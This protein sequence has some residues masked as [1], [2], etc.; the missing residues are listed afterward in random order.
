MSVPSKLVF[1]AKNSRCAYQYSYRAHTILTIHHFDWIFYSSP[2]MT[3]TYMSR[4][5]FSNVAKFWFTPNVLSFL[6]SNDLGLGELL[7]CCEASEGICPLKITNTLVEYLC[8]FRG[9]NRYQ[10]LKTPAQNKENQLHW[11]KKKVLRIEPISAR[12][13]ILISLNAFVLWTE[14]C[15][16]QLSVRNLLSAS[17]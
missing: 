17:I 6:A 14:R 9:A 8:W 4:N 7:G 12:V 15:S 5:C 2:A 1:V 16:L 3:V 11:N 10:K 13:P